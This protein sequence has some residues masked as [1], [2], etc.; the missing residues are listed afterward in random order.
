ML[1]YQRVH[2]IGSGC[3]MIKNERY[4]YIY[5]YTIKFVVSQR[6][7]D[8]VWS[9]DISLP[10]MEKPLPDNINIWGFP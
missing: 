1:V 9:A 2:L 10:A 6:L 5:I 7:P 4:V 8:I 3:F